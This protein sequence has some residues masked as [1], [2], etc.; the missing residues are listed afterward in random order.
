MACRPPGGRQAWASRLDRPGVGPAPTHHM[1]PLETLDAAPAGRLPQGV[2]QRW[3]PQRKGNL[4]G[5]WRGG[6]GCLDIRRNG[7]HEV[8]V[9]FPFALRLCGGERAAGNVLQ[10]QHG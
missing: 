8:S 7:R 10:H 1:L 2:A 9:S 4:P 5:G 3:S 6:S